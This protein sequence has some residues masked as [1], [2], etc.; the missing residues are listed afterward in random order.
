MRVTAVVLMLA[1]LPIPARAA[2]TWQVNDGGSAAT[3]QSPVHPTNAMYDVFIPGDTL[4][5]RS[6]GTACTLTSPSGTPVSMTADGSFQWKHAWTTESE[7]VWTLTCTG[8]TG[9]YP[10]VFGPF[11]ERLWLDEHSA[12]DLAAKFDAESILDDSHYDRDLS[13]TAGSHTDLRVPK[14]TELDE[15][16]RAT[17]WENLLDAR[18]CGFQASDTV[19]PIQT[20]SSVPTAC[21]YSSYQGPVND[22][23]PPVTG[24]LD[25]GSASTLRQYPVVLEELALAAMVGRACAES[26]GTGECADMKLRWEDAND[27]YKTALRFWGDSLVGYTWI[28]TWSDLVDSEMLIGLAVAYDWGYRDLD[29]VR[30]RTW[31]NKLYAESVQH[32]I[33]YGSWP[34]D[35]D[36]WPNHT[37]RGLRNGH[38]IEQAAALGIAVN[39]L[40]HEM[41]TTS[42]TTDR[43]R[44]NSETVDFFEDHVTVLGV[45]GAGPNGINYWQS[46]TEYAVRFIESERMDPTIENPPTTTVDDTYYLN[47]VDW[48]EGV[49]RFL[50]HSTILHDADRF[51][52]GGDGRRSNLGDAE[53][54]DFTYNT[55]LLAR[56][57]AW[58]QDQGATADAAIA[59]RMAWDGHNNHATTPTGPTANYT[60]RGALD[61]VWWRDRATLAPLTSLT[62]AP[63]HQCFPDTGIVT[64]R[65]GWGIDDSTEIDDPYLVFR[66]GRGRGNH[67]DPDA[68]SFQLYADGPLVNGDEHNNVTKR[69]ALHSTLLV[70]GYGQHGDWWG[71]TEASP[72]G[73]GNDGRMLVYLDSKGPTWESSTAVDIVTVGTDLTQLYRADDAD[74][75]RDTDLGQITAKWVSDA[76]GTNTSGRK[77]DEL[78][79]YMVWIGDP[80]PAGGSGAVIVY[81]RFRQTL[82]SGQNPLRIQWRLATSNRTS[83]GARAACTTSAS[84]GWFSYTNGSTVRNIDYLDINDYDD[85]LVSTG[86]LEE[87]NESFYPT[88][89]S[90][91]CS[92][93]DY[94]TRS[95]ALATIDPDD[96]APF[97]GRLQVRGIV[98]TTS[99]PTPIPIAQ[100]YGHDEPTEI[101]LGHALTRTRQVEDGLFL[102]ALL[103]SVD[104][105]GF[106]ELTTFSGITGG[107]KLRV[108]STSGATI[109]GDYDTTML[110]HDPALGSVL[111]P[112]VYDGAGTRVDGRIGI[113]AHDDVDATKRYAAQLV[114]GA[115]L[116]HQATTM[117]RAENS[118]G[119]LAWGNRIGVTWGDDVA[120]G[121]IEPGGATTKVKLWIPASYGSLINAYGGAAISGATVSGGQLV[122]TVG[123][124]GDFWVKFDPFKPTVKV[125][126]SCSL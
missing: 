122:L 24:W 31:R 121:T 118:S 110:F 4:Y 15:W 115:E 2:I 45:D 84:S 8:D 3:Y 99:W 80:N 30:R 1:L 73:T 124:S 88:T 107:V 41:S 13:G 76:D 114:G 38:Y 34:D 11:H 35:T 21:R 59:Q 62:N 97:H 56:I 90:G 100:A 46:D 60:L 9:S 117:L 43:N 69:T 32:E 47:A 91:T 94:I 65:A 119:G 101:V 125:H 103:P 78:S 58:L 49:G 102:H 22:T 68:G 112:S 6:S 105:A 75:D 10:L 28:S 81:D 25:S 82:G 29:I 108:K 27:G 36:P 51:A 53:I 44:W 14:Y 96:A 55:A 61:I 57:A 18:F 109:S 66:G 86:T 72:E 39:V 37:E 48:F 63:T 111:F 123:G 106:A 20:F 98:P 33:H 87:I 95:G 5:V 23:S 54:V 104:G 79:R 93:S 74:V 126:T 85:A 50:Q 17:G 113:I 116:K 71:Q 92:S 77:L 12:A 67:Q 89:M 52:G 70:D 120:Y 7:G 83:T 64:L 19:A 16:T 40:Y 42:M 26:G